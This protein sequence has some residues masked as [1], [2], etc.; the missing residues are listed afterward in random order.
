MCFFFFILLSVAGNPPIFGCDRHYFRLLVSGNILDNSEI[1]INM[2][3]I[4]YIFFSFP[5]SFFFLRWSLIDSTMRE[6]FFAL[7]TTFLVHYLFSCLLPWSFCYGYHTQINY[8]SNITC[9]SNTFR[10]ITVDNFFWRNYLL[11]VTS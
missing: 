1:A 7:E 2:K 5:F 9:I 11:Q 6:V 10:S 3:K 8:S 4:F